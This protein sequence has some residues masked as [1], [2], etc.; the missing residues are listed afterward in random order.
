MN[1]D[2]MKVIKMILD[3]EQISENSAEHGEVIRVD[4]EPYYEVN[5][6]EDGYEEWIPIGD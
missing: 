5:T 4:F 1:K 2:M 6:Y 3:G